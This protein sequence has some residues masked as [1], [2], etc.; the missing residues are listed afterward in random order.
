MKNHA[1]V[2]IIGG[3]MLGCGLLYHLAEEGWTDSI[4]IEKGEL[5][6]GST[7]HAAGQCPSFIGSYNMAKIHH[8]SNMLYPT[9]EEKTGTYVSWHGCGGI[10]LAFTEA[11]VDWFRRVAGMAPNI[12]YDMEI[13]GPNEIK[14]IIP[15]LDVE[16]VI[17]GAYTTMDG[18]MD[19][20]T[21]CNALAAGA[22]QMGAEVS[23]RNRVTDVRALE[24]GEWE[25]IT[26]Q[27]NIT[28]EHVVNAA[29]CYANEVMKWVGGEAP[30]INM[31][32]QY[33]VTE[34]ID[35]FVQSDEEIPVIRDP[36]ASCYY[37][38]EQK[39]ALIGVYETAEGTAEQAWPPHGYPAWE[40]ESELFE[41][42]FE[43]SMPHLE[44]VLKRMPIWAN[45][46][47]KRVVNGAI[48]HT[49]DSN[50]LL[51]PAAGLKNFWMCTGSSVGIAQGGGC[52]KYLAQWMVHGDA[53]I[54][55]V[56]FDPRR[57]GSWTDDDYVRETSFEEYNRM[58][59]CPVA[60]LE[61]PSGREKRTTPLY[62]KLKNRGCVYTKAFGWERPKWFSPDG[63]EEEYGYRR[64]NVFDL[65]G[66]ECKAVRERVGVLDLSS[67]AKF[68][69]TGSDAMTY[70]ARITANRIPKKD[71]RVVLT[72]G[73]SEGGK[74]AAE[75]TMTR[76]AEDDFYL[77]S[78]AACELR[79]LD[80][81]LNAVLDGEDVTITNV[82]DYWGVLVLAG[83]KSRELLSKLTI[84]D[85]SNE[86]FPWFGA[87]KA[88]V[89]NILLRALRVN[90][91]GELG[92]E[93]HCPMAKLEELYDAIIAEGEKHGIADFGVYAVNSLR[94]EKAYKGWGADLTTEITPA[95]ADIERFVDDK[96]GDFTGREA[97]LARKEEGIDTQCVYAEVDVTNAD[98][99]GGETVYGNGN[100]IGVA[101]SGGYGHVT[102]KSLAFAYVDP[103][104]AEPGSSIE[105]DIM[106]T[107][108]TARVL[109]EPA[110]D[111]GN[112]RI[113]A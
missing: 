53:E 66:Q 36:S 14:K 110:W 45:A 50:P 85:L 90:Y 26:E 106:G 99:I 3:G 24:N 8:Y 91:V 95:E 37:R 81:L 86:A 98:V 2:V 38:Q 60:G 23:L 5:T 102:G 12:G 100:V 16:G 44:A 17:A 27:G 52:G 57:F 9:L 61:L 71:G 107:R 7:W 101:T 76:W 67:F 75:F 41:G 64:N 87:R 25:V 13:I 105:I 73:L 39:S 94:M 92:W 11:E 55:M 79:D 70:L 15:Y 74:I 59:A 108:C 33:F 34:P 22:R 69:V 4:L 40:S 54:N 97:W 35:E 47:I 10:R 21:G 78:G 51:G 88:A 46:G 18:H 1:R 56:E 48:S 109:S 93:L 63:R 112:D 104:F 68:A 84:A 29:G 58:Y 19:P 43:R 72:H 62:E 111:P 89:A 80:M 82:T 42:N 103:A 28:C 113:R 49:P 83:P 31:L 20:A 77:L 30:F 96:K 6:S 32:H 65:V